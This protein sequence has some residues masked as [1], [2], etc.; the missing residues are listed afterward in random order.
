M[1]QIIVTSAV[2][3]FGIS[4]LLVGVKSQI[5]PLGFAKLPDRIFSCDYVAY[6]VRN[7][8]TPGWNCAAVEGLSSSFIFI[9]GTAL[10]TITAFLAALSLPRSKLRRGKIFLSRLAFWSISWTS[11]ATAFTFIFRAVNFALG[12]LHFQ[13]LLFPSMMLIVC[14]GFFYYF[15]KN[16]RDV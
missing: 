9:C 3:L 15:N 2:F 4:A 14:L 10:F 16:L 7:T 6:I 11:A 1:M 5:V 12:R 13:A 8:E